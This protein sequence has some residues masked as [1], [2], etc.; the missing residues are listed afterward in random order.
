MNRES[1][2][3]WLANGLALG[4][5][6]LVALLLCEV[7]SRYVLPIGTGV[8]RVTAEGDRLRNW[9]P[10]GRTYRQISSEFDVETTITAVGHRAPAVTGNPDV[11]FLGDSF[12]FGWGIED[13][14][15]FAALY[16]AEARRRC[17]NLGA[18]G[19]G[20]VDQV[21]RL[22]RYLEEQS[23]RPTEVKL[24]VF[25]MTASFSA[26]ND[27]LDNFQSARRAT[28]EE[29]FSSTGVATKIASN[30][31]A[32]G[33]L[34]RLMGQR[35]FLLQHSNLLRLAK[36]YWGPALRSTLVPGLDRIR[37]DESL[38]I[39]HRAFAELD[40]LSGD[41][42]FRYTIHLIHPV[43]D[44]I[45][46]TH[47]DTLRQLEAIAPVPIRSTARL[48]TPD[49]KEYYYAFD[50]HINAAGSRR[51]ADSLIESTQPI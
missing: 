1:V 15:T 43:Q 42:G 12:T 30:D 7:G 14:E 35:R 4:I 47:E 3:S 19:T 44:I 10:S 2:R 45:R 32:P 5:G 27:L 46:A 22:A 40:R 51:I 36:F 34:E 49:P 16:C 13:D 38:R 8:M 26:G 17:A 24:F 48:F 20:T 37:L 29:S 33:A 6:C 31:V 50:G 18:P 41:Y 11:V 21:A 23:W 28:G 9:L 39:T 25:A